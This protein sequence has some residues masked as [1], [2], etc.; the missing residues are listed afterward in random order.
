MHS[1][2]TERGQAIGELMIGLI[3]LCIVMIGLFM[4][5][6]LGMVGVRNTIAVREEVDKY[7]M[8]GETHDEGHLKAVDGDVEPGPFLE[9]LKS[10][11]GNFATYEL[12]SRDYSGQML[13]TR[14]SESSLLFSAAHLT[15]S[16]KVVS[17]PLSIFEHFDAIRVLSAFGIASSLSVTDQLAMPVNPA[18]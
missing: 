18:E 12:A 4:I 6:G 17:D 9:E 7:S 10:G 5:S 11:S 16:R 15:A 8:H 2:K 14:V 3:G 13:N 1:R